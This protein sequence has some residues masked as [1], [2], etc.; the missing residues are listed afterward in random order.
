MDI[1]ATTITTTVTEWAV[2]TTTTTVVTEDT[3]EDTVEDTEVTMDSHPSISCTKNKI[4]NAKLA[5]GIKI[6]ITITDV[7]TM[8]KTT[9]VTKTTTPVTDIIKQP[10]SNSI[11]KKSEGLAMSGS[12]TYL[13]TQITPTYCH[14][15]CTHHTHTSH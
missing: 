14:I 10:K 12:L 11:N 7:D 3:D 6:C 9:T 8:D 2:T 5:S 15:H 13:R 4:T 1:T